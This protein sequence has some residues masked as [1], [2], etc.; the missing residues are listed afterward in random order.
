MRQLDM[1]S[2]FRFGTLAIMLFA[3]AACSDPVPKTDKEMSD[4]IVGTWAEFAASCSQGYVLNFYHDGNYWDG[5]IDSEKYS[6]GYWSIKD[7]TLLL[8]YE[9]LQYGDEQKTV[10]VEKSARKVVFTSDGYLQIV[11][12]D[13]TTSVYHK[14]RPEELSS[15]R[16]QGSETSPL[17]SENEPEPDESPSVGAAGG[18]SFGDGYEQHPARKFSGKAAPLSLT[19]DQRDFVTRLTEAYGQ[20]SNFGGSLVV[21]QFGCGTGCSFAYALDK[22]TGRVTSFPVGGEEYQGMQIHARSDSALVWVSWHPS[23]SWESCVAQAWKFGEA[24][25]SEV[26]A[27]APIDCDDR[28]RLPSI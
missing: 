28:D 3:L 14:C 12:R 8:E 4:A 26:V 21:V 18:I 25:F 23:A 20:P 10:G 2:K 22:R 5:W 15:N 7:K 27:E 19:R 1:V 17:A 9:K 11:E 13:A 16:A 6:E 24:G